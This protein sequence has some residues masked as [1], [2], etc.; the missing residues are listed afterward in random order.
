MSLGKQLRYG[1]NLRRV[2][3][4]LN[5]EVADS[6]E[7]VGDARLLLSK[8]VVVRDADVVDLLQELGVLAGN[9]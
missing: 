1:R 6:S 4:C 8:P 5:E 9:L 3:T 7:A 2:E